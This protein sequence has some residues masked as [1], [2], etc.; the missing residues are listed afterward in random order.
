MSEKNKFDEEISK[1]LMYKEN[2]MR[3]NIYYNENYYNEVKEYLENKGLLKKYCLEVRKESNG[4]ARICS[5][6]SS[7]RLCL[8]YFWEKPGINFEEKLPITKWKA[9]FDA[10][11]V[12][13]N[14]YYECKCHEIFKSDFNISVEYK[15]PL[16]D[17]FNINNKDK[18]AIKLSYKDFE[19]GIEHKR[20]DLWFD[21]KQFLCHLLALAKKN[22]DRHPSSLLN[23]NEDFKLQYLFFIPKVINEKLET[24]YSKLYKDFCCIRDNEKIKKMCQKNN[25]KVLCP[26]FIPVNSFDDPFSKMINKSE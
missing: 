19:I 25:I 20:G 6:A 7:A 23:K 2:M 24:S 9:S 13:T 21:F 14:T 1:S 22:T 17:N 8:C 26:L 12:N 18:T 11:D 5:V 3:D 10:Y 16:N 15:K 4:K